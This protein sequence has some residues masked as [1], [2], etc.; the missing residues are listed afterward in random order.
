MALNKEIL[1][2]TNSFALLESS[3]DDED[4]IKEKSLEEKSL[5]E[6]EITGEVSSWDG[7]TED[8]EKVPSGSGKYSQELKTEPQE[9]PTVNYKDIEQPFLNIPLTGTFNQD[10][11]NQVLDVLVLDVTQEEIPSSVQE[12]KK[13]IFDY[14]CKQKYAPIRRKYKV[15][16]DFTARTCKRK[17]FGGKIVSALSDILIPQISKKLH[18]KGKVPI[19]IKMHPTHG[20]I[21]FYT[22]G[23]F[24]NQHRDSAIEHEFETPSGHIWNCYSFLMG[25]DTNIQKHVEDGNTNVYLLPVETVN[26]CLT[27]DFTDNFTENDLIGRKLFKHSFPQSRIPSNWVMFNAKAVH[28]S[29]PIKQVNKFKLALKL[30]VWCLEKCQDSIILETKQYQCECILC[31]PHETEHKTLH[32]LILQKNGCCPD[33]MKKILRMVKDE[34]RIMCLFD[35]EYR[36]EC[37]CRNCIRE[38]LYGLAE[39]DDYDYSDDYDDRYY[40]DDDDDCNGYCGP[41]DHSS[42]Y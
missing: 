20:D 37:S 18:Q 17:T 3:G 41:S 2:N 22:K 11:F 42:D 13:L 35:Y 27:D 26:M 38:Y 30:D 5:E 34:P 29:I 23:G 24:F 28:A 9:D 33:V 25:I 8:W 7:D 19:D 1:N 12:K 36:L 15:I 10:T 32:P 39:D 6:K 16:H 40:Y 21:L 14:M 31:K 4:S